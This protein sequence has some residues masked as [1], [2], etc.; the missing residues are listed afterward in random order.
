MFLCR[1]ATQADELVVLL[2]TTESF[3]LEPVAVT[4]LVA[5]RLTGLT[6]HPIAKQVLN[7]KSEAGPT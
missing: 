5:T 2:E 1:V 3:T 7:G 6:A 4:T